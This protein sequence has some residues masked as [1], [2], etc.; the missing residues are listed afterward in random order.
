MN[1]LLAALFTCF[2]LSACELDKNDGNNCVWVVF[3]NTSKYP[4]LQI[5]TN[6]LYKKGKIPYKEKQIQR[7]IP[8]HAK[9]SLCFDS[10]NTHYYGIFVDFL[11]GSDTISLDKK[12]S[13]RYNDL[14]VVHKGTFTWNIGYDNGILSLTK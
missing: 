1:K 9:D 10:Y 3:N 14:N 7:T 11:V 13:E 8:P 2:L 4:I 6:S 5:K 12:G